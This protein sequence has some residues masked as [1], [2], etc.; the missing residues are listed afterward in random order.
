MTLWPVE[1]MASAPWLVQVHALLAV[2]ALLLGT[3]ILLGAKGTAAHRWSGRLYVALML[4]A[5]ATSAFIFEGG[6]GIRF[7]GL[8]PFGFIHL[9]ILL[10]LGGLIQGLWHIRRRNVAAHRDA[11]RT[12]FLLSLLVAGAFTLLPGRRMSVMLFGEAGLWWVGWA[13][14]LAL[15]GALAWAWRPRA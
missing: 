8:G 6:R 14:L 12:T 15:A 5:A 10:T 4:G 9:L 7:L 13:G 11:M 2:L 3:A 1:P